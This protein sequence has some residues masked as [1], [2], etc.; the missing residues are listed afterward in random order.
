MSENG[1]PLSGITTASKRLAKTAL[2]VG[3][4][5]LQLLLRIGGGAGSSFKGHNPCV[6]SFCVWVA[7]GVALTIV[8]VLAFWES[9]PVCAASVLTAVYAGSALILNLRL[10]QLRREW[11]AFSGSVSQLQKDVS[12]LTEILR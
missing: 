1:R 3:G 10:T 6:G 4:N 5:R 2:D 7:A 9:H 12:C 8:V 11:V